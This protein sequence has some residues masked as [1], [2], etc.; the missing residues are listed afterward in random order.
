M[1]REEPVARCA[2]SLS[3]KTPSKIAVQFPLARPFPPPLSPRSWLRLVVVLL[4]DAGLPQ[5]VS[6]I[7]GARLHRGLLLL[8]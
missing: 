7:V 1:Y 6:N 4:K 3:I 5:N 2:R 8:A